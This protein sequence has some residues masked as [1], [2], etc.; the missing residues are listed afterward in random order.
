MS[1]YYNHRTRLH[2]LTI[3]YYICRSGSW[4]KAS[5]G[6]TAAWGNI[7]KFLRC[8]H[9]H[10]SWMQEMKKPQRTRRPSVRGLRLVI[11]PGPGA[12]QS[13]HGSRIVPGVMPEAPKRRLYHPRILLFIH[14]YV[15]SLAE[16]SGKRSVFTAARTPARNRTTRRSSHV[17]QPF[18]PLVHPYLA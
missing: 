6:K 10:A 14:A 15:T 12:N 18:Y 2:F 17:T 9:A 4:E 11:R 1:F 13:T 8:S 16:G 3:R 7:D 5:S